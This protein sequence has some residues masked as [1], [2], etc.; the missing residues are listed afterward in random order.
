MHEMSLVR[1]LV[2]IVLGE[3]EGRNV[4]SIR[5]VHL[6]I[7]ELSDVVEEQI[8]GLFHHFARGT[9][10]EGAEV[11]VKRVP[12]YVHCLEC[13]NIFAINVKD[14]SSLSCPRCG[15]YRK[16]RLFSG[17]EFRVDS[18]EIEFMADEAPDEE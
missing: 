5:A 11:V 18:L 1:Q 13:S 14:E 3:C 2:E 12:A 9:L 8:P 4:A 15:A 10:A 7:G 16:Y 6:S 17:R